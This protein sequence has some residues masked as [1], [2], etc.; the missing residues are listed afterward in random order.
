V[1]TETVISTCLVTTRL[2]DSFKQVI[3]TGCTWWHS[4]AYYVVFKSM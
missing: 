3:Y 4:V 2:S 1:G